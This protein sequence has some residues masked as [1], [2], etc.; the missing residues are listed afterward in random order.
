MKIQMRLFLLTAVLMLACPFAASLHAQSM[1]REDVVEIPAIGDGLSGLAKCSLKRTT[2]EAVEQLVGTTELNVGVEYAQIAEACGVRGVKAE[3]MDGLTEALSTAVKDQ[4]ENNVT[5]Y[6]EVVLN[7]ELGEP[8]RR[9]AM[10]APV[11]VA[12][13][14]ASD[15]R[16]QKGS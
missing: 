2:H 4:M 10:K 9:D 15:M 6:I 14:S 11:A 1:P 5:T 13:I 12:G 16:P 3:T 7:Q 8:F